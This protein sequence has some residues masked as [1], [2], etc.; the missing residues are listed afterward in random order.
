MS[1]QTRAFI[2]AEKQAGNN[3]AKACDLLEVSRSAFYASINRP[4]SARDRTDAELTV[5][6]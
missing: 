4:A 5:M 1:A 2:A 6:I 3:V